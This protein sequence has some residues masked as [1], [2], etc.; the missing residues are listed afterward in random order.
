MKQNLTP[1]PVG[2]ILVCRTLL[3]SPQRQSS[4]NPIH[5]GGG[6]DP[7]VGFFLHNCKTR[8]D[9]EKK[10]Y[11]F[12]FTPLMVILHILSITIVTYIHTHTSCLFT[13]GTLSDGKTIWSPKGR[14]YRKNYFFKYDF[15]R[16]FL[17][18]STFVIS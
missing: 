4:I 17:K 11:D 6:A 15:L 7:P 10:L 3:N 18:H 16:F 2:W 9:I 14:C 1:F 13:H 8:Q 12:S 5:G